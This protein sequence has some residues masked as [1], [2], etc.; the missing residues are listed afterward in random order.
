M[1]HLCILAYLAAVIL[2]LFACSG[3]GSIGTETPSSN[4]DSSSS[5]DAEQ[6]EQYNYCVYP[7]MQWWCSE[8][9]FTECQDGGIPSNK[10]PDFSGSSSS[11]GANESEG[12]SSSNGAEPSSSSSAN[13]NENSSSSN[14]AGQ[15][16]QY[17]YC[18]YPE[19]KWCSTGPFTECQSN[20][21]LS[22]EC[23]DFSGS[24]SSESLSS[25]SSVIVEN[26]PC[27][28]FN[29]NEE[30]LHRGKMKKQI[31]DTRD[32]IRYVYVPIGKQTWMAENLRYGCGNTC[33]AYG[34]AYNFNDF[35][36]P[37]ENCVQEIS[38]DVFSINLDLDY[39]KDTLCPSGWHIPSTVELEELLTTADPNFVPGSEASGT[40]HDSAAAKLKVNFWDNSADDY[41][42][43][44]LPPSEPS[45]RIFWLSYGFG[46]P[47]PLSKSWAMYN[48]SNAVYDAFQSYNTTKF[49]ARCLKTVAPV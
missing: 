43:S 17:N 39:G 8:G 44:A 24:S 23:P 21:Q 26:F 45:N 48:G 2:T 42:F 15:T 4:S 33:N 22:D 31:C 6:I 27:E 18:V 14:D 35:Y 16:K 47:H 29:P 49:Y 32:G 46:Y 19:L 37:S 12:S 11:E 10:C 41:G 25:S 34:M 3:D 9:P 38:K 40:G 5:S 28:L 20:G 7:D 13:A 1:K 30:R 36:C